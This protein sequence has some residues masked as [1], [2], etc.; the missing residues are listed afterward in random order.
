M[1]N[2][3]VQLVI[4]CSLICGYVNAINPPFFLS[5]SPGITFGY[6]FGKG[7][8][9]SIYADFG[10]IRNQI[11][12]TNLYHGVNVSYTF[13]T[14]KSEMYASNLYRALSFNYLFK[15]DN[16]AQLKLGMAKT[17]LKWGLNNRN[18]KGTVW[19]LNIQAEAMPLQN[20]ILVGLRYFKLNNQCMGIGGKE[21]KFIYAGFQ[22][23]LIESVPNHVNL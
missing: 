10:L 9:A 5:A 23:N 13:F 19:G 4:C 21:P 1:K 2:K 8:N 14:H 12:T 15:V 16:L 7:W 22:N 20:G 17:K 11:H 6:T 3:I 18:S